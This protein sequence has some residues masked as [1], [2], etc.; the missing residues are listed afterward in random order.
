MIP[1]TAK[2]NEMP[3]AVS[4]SGYSRDFMDGITKAYP[5]KSVT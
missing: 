5:Q 1:R 3:A 2:N 4:R